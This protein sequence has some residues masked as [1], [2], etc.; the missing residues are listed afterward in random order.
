VKGETMADK[1]KRIETN[2]YREP[3]FCMFCG[4]RVL[5]PDNS[6]NMVTPCSHTLFVAHDEAFEYRSS[7]FN[8]SMGFK[9]D[10]DSPEP[11][12]GEYNYD[13]FTDLV[14]IENSIKVA[15]Y[16]PAPSGMGAYVGFAP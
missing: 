10:D 15:I 12:I 2:Q 4:Q 13:S 16:T 1:I 14:T 11:D 6:D 7:R 5:N 9:A 8:T 3:V